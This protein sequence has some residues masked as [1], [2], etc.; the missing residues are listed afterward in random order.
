M[1]YEPHVYQ[2][3]ATKH[4]IENPYSALFLEMGLGKTIATLTAIDEL[5][6]NLYEVQKV[7]VIAPKLVAEETW[8]TEALK[9]EHTKHLTMSLVLGTER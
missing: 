9:W 3:H 2:D 4:I 6:Y 8:T 7:L 5:M 1:R